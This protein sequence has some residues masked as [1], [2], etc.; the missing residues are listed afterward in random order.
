MIT[1]NIFDIERYATKDGPGIRTVVFFKGCNLR[2]SWCQNPESQ[3]RGRQVMY[4]AGQ[5]S[6]CGRCIEVCPANA[7]QIIEPHGY[8][9]DHNRCT[10]CGKCVDACFYGARKM[11]GDD[12]T[13]DKLMQKLLRDRS[14]Y[15]ESGGGITLSGGEPLFQPGAV[16]EIARRCREEGLHTAIE[17]AGSVEWELLERI[18]NLFDLIFYDFKHIDSDEHEKHTGTANRRIMLNLERLSRKHSNIIVRIPVIPGVNHSTDV[19][20]RMMDYLHNRTAVR[21]VELLPFH[22]LGA[23]KYSGLGEDYL[24]ADR[25]DVEKS[26]CLPYQQYGCSLGLTV[27]IGAV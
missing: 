25:V 23:G 24:F 16:F 17:T 12:Y 9:T 5:C 1:V 14:F 3:H 22:R 21:E 4:Y 13:I 18:A 27:R 20:N 19:I 10:A 7:I 11:I 8:I 6:A 15:E 2:C 26:E